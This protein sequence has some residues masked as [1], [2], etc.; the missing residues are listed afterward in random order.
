MQGE[1]MANPEINLIPSILTV[2]AS[3]VLSDP[4]PD[5]ELPDGKSIAELLHDQEKNT[6]KE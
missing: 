5:L 3:G 4:A 1:K 6:K 2:K